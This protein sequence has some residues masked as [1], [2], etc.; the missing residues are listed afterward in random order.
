MN[1]TSLMIDRL[2][3]L[4]FSAAMPCKHGELQIVKCD[5]KSDPHASEI[6][7]ITYSFYFSAQSQ[8][9]FFLCNRVSNEQ[10]ELSPWLSLALFNNVDPWAGK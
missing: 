7:R 5:P 8:Q 10:W 3:Q 4:N 1:Y 6:H 2:R 9:L